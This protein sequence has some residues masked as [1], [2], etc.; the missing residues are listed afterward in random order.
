MCPSQRRRRL[1]QHR[2]GSPSGPPPTRWST[3]CWPR[4]PGGRRYRAKVMSLRRWWVILL[5]AGRRRLGARAAGPGHRARRRR[6][7][8]RRPARSPGPTA[9]CRATPGRWSVRWPRG[10]TA[11]RGPRSARRAEPGAPTPVRPAV[12]TSPDGCAWRRAAVARGHS[13]RAA[14]RLLRSGPARPAGGRPGSVVQPGTRQHP[15]HAV[16]V[17]RR[18]AAAGGRAVAR[19]LRRGRAI[20]MDG[21]VATPHGLPRHG[22]VPRAGRQRGRA[23]LA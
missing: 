23:R 11:C 9:G 1:Y 17:G 2:T 4:C 12:W 22:G 16:A 19:A 6:A 21:L 20:T 7:R 5:V 13:G 18:R 14:H 8:P 3:G 10:A 15:A